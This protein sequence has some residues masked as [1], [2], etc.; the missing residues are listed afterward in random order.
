M[1]LQTG[2]VARRRARANKRKPSQILRLAA[3]RI[4]RRRFLKHDFYDA[5]NIDELGPDDVKV[6]AW[7]AIKWAAFGTPV[8]V[9]PPKSNA[10]RAVHYAELAVRGIE[11]PQHDG[12]GYSSLPGFNDNHKMVEV[13]KMLLVAADLAEAAGE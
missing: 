12:W 5:K 8:T 10:A 7:G 11:I 9:T 3:D 1:K 13:R 4:T 2:V 6:C